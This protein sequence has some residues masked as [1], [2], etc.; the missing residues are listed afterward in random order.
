MDVRISSQQ[1]RKEL[2]CLKIED[3]QKIKNLSGL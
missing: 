3:T 2:S 1:K